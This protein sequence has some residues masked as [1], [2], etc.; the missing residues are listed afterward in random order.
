MQMFETKLRHANCIYGKK[1]MSW[2][3]LQQQTAMKKPNRSWI[4]QDARSANESS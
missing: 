1:N 4:E 2:R 3:P